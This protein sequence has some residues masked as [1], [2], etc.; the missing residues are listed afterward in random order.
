MGSGYSEK[1]VFPILLLLFLSAPGTSQSQNPIVPPGIYIADPSAHVWQDGKLYIYGSRDESPDYFCSYRYHVLSTPDLETWTLFPDAFASK[2]EADAV[3]YSD[4]YLYAPD[5]QY[6]N[7][8]YYL[9]YC[10][11]NR[12]ATE[13]IAVSEKPEGPFKGGKILKTGKFNEIDP[14]VFMDDDGQGYY[15]WGQF[16]AKIA[17]L[18]PNM[19]EIDSTTIRDE[20]VTEKEHRFHEGG[21]MVK[22]NGIY[23]FIYAGLSIKD[24]PTCISYATSSSPWGPFKYGGVIINNDGCDPGNWNNHGSLVEFKKKWYVFYHRSTHN[25]KM[26]RKAC[27][28]PIFFNSDGSINEVEMTSQGAG[29]PISAFQIIEAERACLLNGHLRVQAFSDNAEELAGIY[30]RDRAVYKYIDFGNG[31]NQLTLRVKSKGK[32]GKIRLIPDKP[33]LS[34][35]ASVDMKAFKDN[36]DWQEI[37]VKTKTIKGIHALWLV[38]QGEEGEL[39]SV[40]WFKFANSDVELGE[41]P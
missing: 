7:G 14:C 41:I 35:I 33:W 28:E 34:S 11:A 16:S 32:T 3:L 30:S 10:L 13:G 22:R 5:V 38:T 29:P 6:K 8:L 1:I 2:G 19:M 24:M 26:M 21:Y 39:F 27:V 9:Y 36:S 37:T 4:D 17:R 31:A 20:I 18:K 25:S 15:I 40:D 12:D 23:Y